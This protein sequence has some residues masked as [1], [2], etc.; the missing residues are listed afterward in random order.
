M[1]KVIN[2]G[3]PYE[4]QVRQNYRSYKI[5]M[6]EYSDKE[7]DLFIKELKRLKPLFDDP[8]AARLKKAS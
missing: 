2:L 3:F 5:G 4:R 7:L 8:A 6:W 1:K